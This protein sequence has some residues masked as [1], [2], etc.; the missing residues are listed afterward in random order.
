MIRIRYKEFSA[1]THSFSGLHGVARRGARGVTVYLV[2]GLTVQERKAVLRRLRQEGSRGFG[3]PLP[4]IALVF[5]LCADRVRTTTGTG[6]SLIRLH[7]AVTLLP[8]AFVAA[9]MTLFVFA[10]AGRSV[11]FR[12]GPVPQV[13]GL[14]LLPAGGGGQNGGGQN[15]GA[16]ASSVWDSQL[17]SVDVSSGSAHRMRAVRLPVLSG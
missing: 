17:F 10:C 9:V 3:P 11:D 13:G 1:G 16:Q 5:A 14:A 7:P 2:P 8:S 4:P 15:G 12:T 6:A